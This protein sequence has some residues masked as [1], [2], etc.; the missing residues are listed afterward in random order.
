MAVKDVILMTICIIVRIIMVI[1][2]TES[3]TKMMANFDSVVK[4]SIV[5][6]LSM[7]T[8]TSMM[9][10]IRKTVDNFIHIYFFKLHL[11]INSFCKS[12]TR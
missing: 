8:T 9:R 7:M 2:A 10:R 11:T 4:N 6:T 12:G 1:R 3:R 5:M